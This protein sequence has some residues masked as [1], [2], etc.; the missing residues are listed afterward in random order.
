MNRDVPVVAVGVRAIDVGYRNV[1]YTLGRKM[2]AGVNT[3]AT[4]LFPSI[5]PRLTTKEIIKDAGIDACIVNVGGADYIVGPAAVNY[6]Q[7]GAQQAFDLEYSTS[8]RYHAQMQGALNKMADE[9]GAG[10]EFVIGRLVLGLPLNTYHKNV[11]A[12]KERAIGEHIIRR[13]GSYL[14]RRVTVKDVHV[15]V[16]AHGALLNFG[17]SR[18]DELKDDRFRLV[19]DPG[20]GTLDWF[21][22]RGTTPNWARCGA[23]PKAMLH[24]AY[25]IAD[26]I[27]PRWRTQYEIVEAIDLA[28]RK[29]LEE[30]EIGPRRFRMNEFRGAVDNVVEESLKHMIENT[31]ELDAVSR[32]IITG[33]G[34]PVFREFIERRLPKLARITETQSDPVFAN[35]RGFQVAGEVLE[36]NRGS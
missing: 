32:I 13:P 34:A 17:V 2:V 11:D 18:P 16:Q 36:R 4:G 6:T 21:M 9:A 3:I 30:F 19:I 7:P 10:Q 20:G 33:G 31:G 14:Y 12:L 24:C 5:A 15:M 35:V 26:L 28:L 8:D 25:A 23:H 1:K 27:N 22:A 29:N